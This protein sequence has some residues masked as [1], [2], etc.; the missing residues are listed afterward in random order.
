MKPQDIQRILAQ[1]DAYW[2][3][4]RAELRELKS[5]YMTRFWK[6]RLAVPYGDRSAVLRT[7]LPKAYAVVES[8]LGSLYAKNPAVIVGADIRGRGNPE[9]SQ[10]T[11]NR[12]LLTCREQLED[13]T[14][15]A[16]CF[17][18]AFLKLAPVAN[19]DPLKR[20]ST[21]A[22][23]PWEVITD[24]TASSWESQRYVGHVYLMPLDEAAQR[25]NR[26]KDGFSARAYTSWIDQTSKETNPLSTD[27]GQAVTDE[28]RWVRVVEFYDL[29]GDELLVYSPDYKDGERFLFSGVKVQ[30]GALD[31]DAGADTGLDEVEQET[32]HVTSGIPYK[33][34]SGQAVAPIIPLYFSRDPEIPLRGYSLLARIRDQLREA[35]IMRTYQAQG[36]RR[37]ARQWLVR[38]GFLSESAASKMAQGLDGE[39]IE[40]DAPPGTQIAGEIVPVPNPPIPADVSLYGAQVLQDIDSAGVLAPFTRGEATGT[41]ATE[42]RLLAA[43]S[44]SEVGR[45]ARIRDAVISSAART[46]NIMLSVMLGDEAEPLS[47]PNP[48][49]PTMLSADDLTG[50]F[51]YW[52]VDAG[53]TPMS[54]LTKQQ[55][56]V[57]QAGLLLQLGVSP[58]KLRAEIIRAFDFPE[59]FNVVEPPPPAAP[60]PAPV[61]EGAPGP[62]AGMLPDVPGLPPNRSL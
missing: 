25:Y 6:E 13:A 9:V 3:D 62:D 1:H 29:V 26:R 32:E 33:S 40:V 2:D 19:V 54:D 51:D 50:D 24:S 55:A 18:C 30:V 46:Y 14:R 17:P 35:N 47:L 58:E 61:E 5:F 38:E 43:Y 41:T 45:M 20:V 60:M 34:A 16:L 49:G 48:I 42:Q 27:Y 15:L 56:L 8:Y 31:P 57:S 21:A 53:S 23:P 7:E 22:V 12:Y 59:D 44:S 52:A 28:G 37:M 11:A 10:A 36:V 4:Q 39:F